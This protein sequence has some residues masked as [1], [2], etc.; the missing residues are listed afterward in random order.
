MIG[1]TLTLSSAMSLLASIQRAIGRTNCVCS[2]RSAIRS[3]KTA[4]PRTLEVA[5]TCSL[6]ALMLHKPG[7]QSAWQHCQNVWGAPLPMGSGEEAA[8][9][10]LLALPLQ[11]DAASVGLA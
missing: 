8:R 7:D 1:L 4:A 5:W 3:E 6:R 9:W 10:C 2:Q 11:F